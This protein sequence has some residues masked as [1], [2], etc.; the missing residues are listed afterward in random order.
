VRVLVIDNYDSFTYNLVQ[1]LGELGAEIDVVRNDRATVEELLEREADRLVVSP[2]PC[3]PAEA[4]ISVDAIR[5]FAERGTP[6]L[7]VCLGHQSL[8]EAF[9]GRTIVGDPIHGKDAEIEH[10]GRALFDGLPN[11]L[12]AGRYHSLVADPDLPDE[13]ERSASLGD[14]VMGARHRE[15]PAEGV[16]FHPES[17]LTPHGKHLLENFLA[18]GFASKADGGTNTDR[19]G[20]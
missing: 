12:V 16:Q 8:V 4:G 6:V 19:E 5:A 15:L 20:R 3:T 17:V 9:G 13:L 18:V 1:Y 11:P 10:D 7:G 14:V 2:G